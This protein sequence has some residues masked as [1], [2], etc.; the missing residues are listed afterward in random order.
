MIAG[1]LHPGRRP[2]IG[3]EDARSEL[4]IR[5]ELEAE[6]HDLRGRRRPRTADDEAPVRHPR[7]VARE[8]LG[9][10]HVDRRVVWLEIVRH[11]DD[12][13]AHRV[14]VRP[15]VEDDEALARVPL[16]N[17]ELGTLPRAYTRDPGLRRDRVLDTVRDA[18]HAPQR[19]GVPLAE[20]PPPEGV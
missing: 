2:R 12:G 9:V 14:G 7:V 6:L 17:R 10:D 20:P 15:S 1:T 5:L 16:S 3:D 19:V 8:L 4:R 11:L 13:R 18:R